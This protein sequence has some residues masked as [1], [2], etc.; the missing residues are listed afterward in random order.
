VSYPY[1]DEHVGDHYDEGEFEDRVA[2]A[3]D[4]KYLSDNDQEF[5]SD[6]EAKF[7]EYGDEMFFSDAQ[8][9]YLNMLSVRGG[10]RPPADETDDVLR[11]TELRP[12]RDRA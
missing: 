1:A 4:S 3:W 10:Y 12:R 8:A 5:L 7:D 9:K 6:I 11:T 2:C